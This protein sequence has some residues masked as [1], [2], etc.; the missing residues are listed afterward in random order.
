MKIASFPPLSG[1]V[2][3][4]N[5]NTRRMI[6]EV[7]KTFSTEKFEN[8]TLTRVNDLACFTSLSKL[9]L[10][11]LLPVEGQITI[12][13]FMSGFTITVTELVLFCL[14]EKKQSAD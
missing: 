7:K 5:E 10:A 14:W 12:L 1:E 13:L 4:V 8:K 9:L 2:S 11:V 6:I 3:P